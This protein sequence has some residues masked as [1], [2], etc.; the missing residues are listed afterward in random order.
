MD[1]AYKKLA[2]AVVS[3]YFRYDTKGAEVKASVVDEIYNG[4]VGTESDA[5]C[6]LRPIWKAMC[7]EL[8]DRF[9]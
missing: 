9:Q 2:E 1:E 7:N 3:M 6:V 8:Q 5:A 4:T